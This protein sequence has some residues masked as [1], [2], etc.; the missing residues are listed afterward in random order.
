MTFVRGSFY[1]TSC[2]SSDIRHTRVRTLSLQPFQ[3]LFAFIFSFFTSDFI[4]ILITPT[5]TFD[6]LELYQFQ[7]IFIL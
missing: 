2:Y 7:N 6:K 3:A 5:H 4:L 1:Q